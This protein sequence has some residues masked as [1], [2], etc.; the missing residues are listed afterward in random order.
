MYVTVF[1]DRQ[2]SL[3]AG[4]TKETVV[5]LVGDAEID[6]SAAPGPGASLTLIAL[7]GDAAIRVPPGTKVTGGG[8]GLLGDRK[9]QVSPG[10]GPEVRINV[11]K[12]VG[13]LKVTETTAL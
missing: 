4:W 12:L 9:V 3:P 11:Y 6:A 10:D 13:D 5:W 8:F 2:V 7:V 1:G